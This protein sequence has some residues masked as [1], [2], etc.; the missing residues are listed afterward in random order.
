MSG[1]FCSPSQPSTRPGACSPNPNH[2]DQGLLTASNE[3]LSRNKHPDVFLFL[4]S[5]HGMT[6]KVHG[7]SI[8]VIVAGYRA[9][10]NARLSGLFHMCG[11]RARVGLMRAEMNHECLTYPEIH[12][13]E[14]K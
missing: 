7:H 6:R 2:I 8:V 12:A 13:E 5:W 1:L 10:S 4:L 11:L 14:E 9:A 3:S